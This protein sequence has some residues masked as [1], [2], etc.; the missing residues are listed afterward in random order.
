MEKGEWWLTSCDVQI[1]ALMVWRFFLGIG[2][3]GEYP[4]GSV[5]C[6]ESS[7][8]RKKGRDFIFIIFTNTHIGLVSFTAPPPKRSGS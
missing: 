7:A 2:I 6:A 5:A 3:G 4:S 8:Q 1:Q